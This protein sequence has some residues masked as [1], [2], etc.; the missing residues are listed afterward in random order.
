VSTTVLVL[1]LNF[2]VFKLVGEL[3]NTAY[4]VHRH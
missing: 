4:V 3:I 1:I 2:K